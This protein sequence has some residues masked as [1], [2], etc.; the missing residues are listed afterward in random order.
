M[1]ILLTGGAGYI[2]S[3][4]TLSLLAAGHEPVLFDDF[5]NSSPQVVDRLSD[6]AGRRLEAV[7]GRLQDRQLTASVLSSHGIE[8]V[9]HFAASKSVAESVADPL[10]YH[11]NNVGGL[12]AL[13]EAMESAA[14]RTIVFSS[15]ATVYGDPEQ[16]PIPE[17]HP[18]RAA[19]PY[20]QTKLIC[21]N[22]LT[23]L[24]R[25]E[26]GWR[27]S[28]LRY[29]NPVGAHPSGLIGEEPRGAPTNLMPL[30]V[31]AALGQGPA[32]PILGRDYPT[33][34]GTAVRDYLHVVDLAEGHA[35]ALA[36]LGGGDPLQ[37]FNLGTGRG[38]SVLELVAAF[39]QATGQAVPTVD[40]D[41]RSGDVAQLY[42]AVGK[43]ERD[44]GWSATRT[45][46]EMC[47]DSWRFASRNF[48]QV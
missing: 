7:R 4:T 37:L 3:H 5:S 22:M 41:R 27:V 17:E 21:E 45:L 33:A 36:A 24:A 32:L 23:D 18:T 39:E 31:R 47:A 13:L 14:V 19:N 46:A 40:A 8:A 48:R 20:G 2:G 12:L 1:R 43:A 30:I 38:T 6:L 28:L 25:S 29:F 34:D 11:M 16:L 44:L 10:S 15:S 9:I 26:R 42:A 35:A